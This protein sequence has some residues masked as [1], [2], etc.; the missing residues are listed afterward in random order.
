MVEAGFAKSV[1]C[2]KRIWCAPGCSWF[3]IGHLFPQ[4]DVTIIL[5]GWNLTK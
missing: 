4:F 2:Q 3:M 5:I 1:C